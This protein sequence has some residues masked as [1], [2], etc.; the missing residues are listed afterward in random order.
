MSRLD[1]RAV[2]AGGGPAGAVAALVLARR[3]VPTVVLEAAAG[4]RVKI[5]EC[6]PPTLAPLLS[7][8]GLEETLVGDGHLRSQGNR[9]CWGSPVPG[10]RHFLAGTHGPGW[11]LDRERFESRLAAAAH[12]AG[13]DWRWGERVVGCARVGERWQLEIVG[14]AGRWQLAADFLI[15]ATGRAA[16]LARRLGARRCRYDRLMGVAALL[17]SPSPARDSFTL[18]EA[19]VEGW[20]YSA[21]LPD[22]RLS[23]VLMGDSD[24]LDRRLTGRDG[25]TT[26]WQ[27]LL[28]TQVTRERVESHGYAPVG[29]VQ[30]MPAESS[31]LETIAGDG[32]L[33]AG[34]AA[35]AYD[36]LSSHGIGS[37]MGAGF[38]AGHAAAD[39]LA[40]RED[41][42]LAYLDL[43]QRA[44][45]GYLDLQRR[46]YAREQRWPDAPF[47][48]RRQ[49]AGYG[50]GG[51]IPG[52]A[53][54]G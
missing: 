39:L 3:G 41:A 30:A 20:W 2:V 49:A 40:G 17:E 47:W 37:A 6:L 44:Y 48:R 38:Y 32:W 4:P 18:I 28:E 11:H 52:A 7:H 33:A 43:L 24:L 21:L 45:G 5:G 31:R 1:A 36:P 12:Q 16:R 9:F 8:L 42:R 29:P 53:N 13:A 51:S 23:V 10:E 19:T 14:A 34:D 35:A 50:V 15:D 26:W 27:K 54:R 25:V 22:G 46:E